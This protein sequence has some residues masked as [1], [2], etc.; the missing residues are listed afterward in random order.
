MKKKVALL[1]VVAFIISI[2]TSIKFTNVE[3]YI[4]VYNTYQYLAID[5][6]ECINTELTLVDYNNILN[7]NVHLSFKG[8]ETLPITDSQLYKLDDLSTATYN[9]YKLIITFD[10]NKIKNRCSIFDYLIIDNGHYNYELPIGS[11]TVEKNEINNLPPEVNIMATLFSTDGSSYNLIVENKL[12]NDISINNIHYSV[13]FN[14]N[15][16][17]N[18]TKIDLT[19]PKMSQKEFNIVLEDDLLNKNIII[20]P[21]LTV[22][23]G[24]KKYHTLSH[25]CIFFNTSI[26]KEQIESLK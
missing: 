18:D 16:F 8:S 24:E 2:I 26:T 21:R 14:E 1:I 5:T 10:E 12:E 17:G 7:D 19:I 11:I 13:L 6:D 3:K 22:V 20:R 25:A 23:C 4:F 9:V 15:I